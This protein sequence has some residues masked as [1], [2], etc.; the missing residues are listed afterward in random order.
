MS[1][2]IVPDANLMEF[3][4]EEVQAAFAKKHIPSNALIEFYL[5]NLLQEFKK[6][7]KLFCAEGNQVV[8]KPLA[9]L[10]AEALSGDRNTRILYLKKLG[11]L[12]LY[13]SGFF[14]ESLPR[15][16]VDLDYYIRMGGGAYKSLSDILREQKT[17]AEL[18]GEL[19]QSF[20]NWVTIISQI[21]QKTYQK[22]DKDL[23]AIYEKWVATGDEA[24]E[25]I[26]K[27]AG[28]NTQEMQHLLKPQ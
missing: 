19:S 11:D 8:E 5:V 2:R 23:L 1:P 22:T 17:F 16:L 21:A 13:I 9:T 7:E 18:Y 4:R 12:A 24:L 3:F 20:P 27:E 6:T 10:L 14:S 28:I 15:K 26:L 25:Q